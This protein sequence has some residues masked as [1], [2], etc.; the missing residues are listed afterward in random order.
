MLGALIHHSQGSVL[1]S[2]LIIKRLISFVNMQEQHRTIMRI[3]PSRTKSSKLSRRWAIIGITVLFCSLQFSNA[4]SEE[5]SSLWKEEP[6]VVNRESSN[7]SSEEL[8]WSV[9]GTKS[10]SLLEILVSSNSTD[11]GNETKSFTAAAAGD[12][13]E[14]CS[15]RPKCDEI[16]GCNAPLFCFNFT[17]TNTT[18]ED[19]ETLLVSPRELEGIVE[20]SSAKNVCAI[21]LFYAPWCTFSVQFARK[22]NALGRSFR[23][24]PILAVNLAE[25]EPYVQYV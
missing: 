3:T 12:S 4:L 7:S 25:S 5:T 23:G 16:N 21:V 11:S 24:L 15:V 6:L 18:S 13:G 8:T 20:D 22:F 17:T 14:V 19:P 2:F 10:P 1:S 9:C